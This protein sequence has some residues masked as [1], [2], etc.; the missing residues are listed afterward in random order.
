MSYVPPAARTAGGNKENRSLG[1][2]KKE[3]LE[4]SAP[5][6]KHRIRITLSSRKVDAVEKVKRNKILHTSE[7]ER[8]RSIFKAL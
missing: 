2:N 8:G 4:E 3:G 1:A 5:V 7:R 6:Q